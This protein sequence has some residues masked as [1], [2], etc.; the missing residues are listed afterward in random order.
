MCILSLSFFRFYILSKFY[1]VVEAAFL[2]SQFA[3]SGLF[4][5]HL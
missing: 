2:K 4:R 3:V 1:G 5:A